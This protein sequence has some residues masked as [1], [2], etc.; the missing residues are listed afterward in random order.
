MQYGKKTDK[1]SDNRNYEWGKKHGYES[2]VRR[3]QNKKILSKGLYP[4]AN[5]TN[6]IKTA[7]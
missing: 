3:E 1:G 4:K 2:Y 7:G 6:Y 5:G